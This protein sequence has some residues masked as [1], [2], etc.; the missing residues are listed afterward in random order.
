M[1][2][3]MITVQLFSICNNTKCKVCMNLWKS[4][5]IQTSVTSLKTATIELSKKCNYV[6]SQKPFLVIVALAKTEII[7]P[8]LFRLAKH[9][10][11]KTRK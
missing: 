10:I 11:Y 4:L 5:K 2:H 9:I 6:F 1:G 3:C 7:I 8:L